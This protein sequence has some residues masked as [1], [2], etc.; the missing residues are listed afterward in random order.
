MVTMVPVLSD[1]E[2]LNLAFFFKVTWVYRHFW[3]LSTLFPMVRQ[4]K[5]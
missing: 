4:M 3:G 2:G 1:L 5:K